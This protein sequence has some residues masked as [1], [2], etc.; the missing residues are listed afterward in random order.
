SIRTDSRRSRD[1]LEIVGDPA[2][3][4]VGVVHDHARAGA[5]GSID[6]LADVSGGAFGELKRFSRS[7]GEPNREPLAVTVHTRHDA[8]HG[9]QAV[10]A[11]AID[12][13]RSLL[14]A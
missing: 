1:P 3:R 7:V 4:L 12:F 2:A 10:I 9:A 8:L 6:V 5:D 11:D 13:D 14:S